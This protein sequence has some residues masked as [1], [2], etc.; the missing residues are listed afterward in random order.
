MHAIPHAYCYCNWLII[1]V[2]C[3]FSYL[4]F[5]DPAFMDS[6][7]FSPEAILARREYVRLITAGFLH[8][9]GRHLLW[10]MVSLYFF[11]PL[12]ELL[13]GP[14]EFLAIYFAALIGGNLLSLYVHRNHD[15][16]ALGASGA[17]SG[18]IFAYI[19]MFPG[20]RINPFFLP[21]GIPA[22]LYA[23]AYIALSFHGMHRQLGDVGHDAHL[24]G[25]LV[26]L[27][28]AAA[29]HPIMIRRSP[30]LFAGISAGTVLLFIYLA[31]NPLFLP[32]APID[33][34]KRKSGGT[35][36][37]RWFSSLFRRQKNMAPPAPSA[38]WKER[39]VDEILQK[40]SANGLESLTAEEKEL[41]N[42]TSE[43]YRRKART[44]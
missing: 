18:V 30:W 8:L 41:L 4:G 21:L 25:A 39:Q 9:N 29:F 37:R 22:W 23:I 20:G 31:Q 43:E 7:L 13:F 15:Y 42:Q 17:V 26:G 5:R 36:R 32:F 35:S 38:K 27:F 1:A 40:I 44:T 14:I 12:I 24:G 3:W 33:F 10:N 11:G 16:R 19:F 34:S 6:Y 2:T 28:T